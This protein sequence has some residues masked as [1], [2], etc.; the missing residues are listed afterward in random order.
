MREWNFSVRNGCF[1]RKTRLWYL[2][3]FSV[4]R[5]RVSFSVVR[6]ESPIRPRTERSVRIDVNVETPFSTVYFARRSR[7]TQ[8]PELW[9]QNGRKYR[10]NIAYCRRKRDPY[11]AEGTRGG[12][13]TVFI[14]TD[15]ETTV[16]RPK[17]S[18]C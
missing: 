17:L 7:R 12:K 3:T 5:K 13:M 2:G 18:A 10:I 11:P 1:G 4:G 8:A 14:H 9:V 6:F 15:A 16:I